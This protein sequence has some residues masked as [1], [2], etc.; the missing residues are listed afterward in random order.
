MSFEIR[1]IDTRPGL[2]PY[3][4]GI[5]YTSLLINPDEN[6][7]MVTQEYRDNSTPANQYH[8]VVMAYTIN[9]H[10]HEDV[11]RRF[12]EG[13]GKP[14]IQAIIDGHTAGFDGNN[15]RGY[16]TNE[17]QEAKDE[18]DI[19]LAHGHFPNHYE[20]WPVDEWYEYEDIT[21]QTTDEELKELAKQNP[22]ESHVIL[23]GDALEY[24]TERRDECREEDES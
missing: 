16:L 5:T 6:F 22:D 12:L 21:A 13:Y 24:L 4:G 3:T 9:D 14:L 19:Q 8:G 10:P 2:D 15:M 11:V 7:V 1:G 17:A 23:L 20:A 18:L